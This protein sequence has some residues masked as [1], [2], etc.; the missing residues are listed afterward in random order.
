[1]GKSSMRPIWRCKGEDGP[2]IL[3]NPVLA[4][5]VIDDGRR[6]Y[7][8]EWCWWMNGDDLTLYVRHGDAEEATY[9]PYYDYDFWLQIPEI[10]DKRIEH[11]LFWRRMEAQRNQQRDIEKRSEALNNGKE[12]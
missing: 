1:M 2:R 3:D 12:I 10:S 9:E 4:V 5:R 8:Y 6:Y 11:M 7:I